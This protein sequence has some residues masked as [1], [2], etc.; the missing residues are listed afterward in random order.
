MIVDQSKNQRQIDMERK[1]KM[2]LEKLIQESR[3]EEE[4]RYEIW[5]ARQCKE[6][7]LEDRKLRDSQYSDKLIEM[8][9]REQNREIDMLDQLNEQFRRSV[10]HYEARNDLLNIEEAVDNRD[11]TFKKCKVL[12]DILFEITE[13]CYKHV[14]D[15][16]TEDIDPRFWNENVQL[17]EEITNPFVGRSLRHPLSVQQYEKDYNEEPTYHKILTRELADYWTCSGQ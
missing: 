7:I 13:A 10:D 14:Q 16:N 5:R 15:G 12:V 6:V 4:I 11:G 9:N 17:F 2:L 8:R 1:Q 3:Q